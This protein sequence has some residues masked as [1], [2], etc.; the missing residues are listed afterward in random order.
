MTIEA[1]PKP[2]LSSH[3]IGA[4]NIDDFLK[5]YVLIGNQSEQK[6][7]IGKQDYEPRQCETCSFD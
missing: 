1:K 2:K 4:D 6:K 7:Y 5:G 3:L